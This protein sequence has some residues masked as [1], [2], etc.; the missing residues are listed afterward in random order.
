MA[1]AG[2]GQVVQWRA[3]RGYRMAGMAACVALAALSA[4]VLWT[5][6]W[7]AILGVTLV[8]AVIARTWWVLLRPSTTARPDGVH[9]VG[10][11]APVHLQWSEIRRV[12]PTIEGLKITCSGG[13]EV[14]ARY[15]Q[16]PS[17]PVSGAT[18]ADVTAAYLAQRAAWARKPAGPEPTYSPP[19]K[20]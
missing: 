16:Q 15:P 20:N 9:I 10:E 13:R 1:E 14:L 11:R 5:Y 7:Y 3:S 4:L 19:A 17:R 2:V 12:E 6:G 18:E 8:A